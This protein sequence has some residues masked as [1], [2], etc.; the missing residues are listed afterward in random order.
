MSDVSEDGHVKTPEKWGLP[1]DQG[2]TTT[3]E[4]SG[5]DPL[6]KVSAGKNRG[7]LRDELNFWTDV[8]KGNFDVPTDPRKSAVA[9]RWD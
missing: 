6:E 9:G 4:G 2:E 7:S 8:A 1:S 5:N 3:G